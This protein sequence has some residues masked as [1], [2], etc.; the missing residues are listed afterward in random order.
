MSYTP[1]FQYG[2]PTE[3]S[4]EKIRAGLLAMQTSLGLALVFLTLA[5]VVAPAHAAAPVQV[6]G[7]GSVVVGYPTKDATRLNPY[8]VRVYYL[9]AAGVQQFKDIPVPNVVKTAGLPTPTKAQVEAASAAKAALII[10]AIN[11]AQIPCKPVTINGTTYNTVTAIP[12]FNTTPGMYAT[13]QFLPPKVVNGQLVREP[14][15][16]AADFTGYTVNGVTQKIVGLGATAQLESPVYLTPGS[17]TTGEVG[18]G[19]ASFSPGGM[20]SGVTSK[21]SFGGLGSDTGSATGLDA[22]G[23]PSV[24]GFGFI[25]LTSSMPAHYLAAFQPLVG[26]TDASVLTVLASLFTENFGSSGFTA[27]YDPLSDRLSIDQSL[28]SVDVTWSANS[29]T[30][31]FLDDAISPTPEPGTLVLVG[32]LLL[33]LVVLRLRRRRWGAARAGRPARAARR[34]RAA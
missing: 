9:D 19:K 15:M 6:Q 3:E 23:N 24:V 8:S 25:D 12:N 31:L 29:D 2:T 22:S 16:A 18:N 10:A 33:G 21:M 14:V 20:P 13:G 7:S 28:P 1:K 17:N 27:S 34:L 30:G 4:T 11:A 5:A 32:T 26:M